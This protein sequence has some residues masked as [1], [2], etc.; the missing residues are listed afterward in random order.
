[1]PRDPLAAY[2]R[3]R[4]L[5]ATPEPEGRPEPAPAGAPRFVVQ[6][7]S[8][9]RLH[10]DLRLE[11]DG[12]LASWA[13]PRY[14]PG[15]PGDNRIAVRTE[16]HPLEYLDF[17]GEIPAGRYGAGT[18]TIHDRGTYE[19][20][21]WEPRKVE[22]ELHG[23]RLCGR[24]A[25]FATGRAEAG[26]GKDWMIHRMGAPA[27]PDAEPLPERIEPMLARP[28]ELPAGPGWAF[29]VK[30][31]GV[32]A[33][34]RSEPGRMRLM[35][36]SGSDITARYPEL[37]R[38]SR[39]LHEHEALLDGE[40]VAFGADGTPSFQALQRRMHVDDE[41]RIRRLA[42]EVPVTYV[43]F[44]LLHLDGHSLIALP[45]DE[46]RARLEALRLGGPHWQVPDADADGSALL[47]A[48][49]R[50]KLEGVVAK[51]R[52]APYEPG[53]RSGAWLKVR[54]RETLDVVIGGWIAGE[55]GRRG[56]IGALLVG[57]PDEDGHLRYRGRVG[58]GFSD[59]AL[60]DLSRRLAPLA[61]ERSPFAPGG[62]RPPRGARWV[63]PVLA[64][65]AGFTE[66]SEE[67]LLR[68]PV[69]LGLREEPP[70]ALVLRDEHA[71]RGRGRVAVAL[72][73][74][75][76]IPVTN[77][78]KP[79]YPDGTT[80]RDVLEYAAAIAPVLVPHLRGRALTLRRFPDGTAGE[81]FFEKRVPPHAPDWV[82]TARVAYG[83]ETIRQVLAD[84]PG[85]L[86][87]LAQLAALELH[88][89]LA[90]AAAPDRPT[91]LVFDLDPGAPAALPE[92]CRVALLVRA[93]LGGVGLRALPKTSGSKGLQLYVPL[94]R[95][96]PT[97]EDTRRV[98]QAVAEVLAH[99]EPGLVVARQ[100][101]A[102]RRGRV[103]V[104]WYQNDRAKTTVAAYSL[105]ARERP[106]VSMPLTWD[107]VEA[108]AGG[109][110]P[111]ALVLSWRDALTR[112][113]EQGD[114][115]GEVLTLAQRLPPA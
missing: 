34:C 16:D 31:D 11:H 58:T 76:E 63:E 93:M 14:L 47:A 28:G 1:V 2:R 80:K 68:H 50:L 27:D 96:E 64:G 52:G 35:A 70:A 49:E 51:R 86:V 46:R 99:E 10:W 88:P 3:K 73:G 40:V 38:L 60:E 105:R 100:A 78:D 94:N 39:D 19:L 91:V 4:D 33:L 53:R 98:A 21:T 6:E 7:H 12:V 56:R 101:K 97:F 95:P 15:D 54:R 37:A 89:S 66:R 109:G 36:R 57:E 20:L 69:W 17:E 113:A 29:E 83:R 23:E 71:E 81:A 62:P 24:W 90:R 75:R 41:R 112:V 107:E 9:T 104:D 32:R 74:G 82:A 67:G 87:W 114:L 30:W 42:A 79:L 44:D 55:G 85:T 61:R 22:V 108:C 106:T 115:F 102:A 111:A 5:S 92:C 13:L 43:I 77:L 48:A 110:D 65:E 45:Y 8:A 84:E 26:G 25:L 59:L 103:L 18:M 72:A